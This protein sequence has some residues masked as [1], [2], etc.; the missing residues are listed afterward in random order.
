M[1]DF[2]GG[3]VRC[4]NFLT[5]TE[6][7]A[8]AA[9]TIAD[10]LMQALA[11]QGR[12]CMAVSGGKTPIRLF[13]QLSQKTLDWKNITITLVDERWLP[14]EHV[15]NN[16]SLVRSH[17]LQ[18]YASEA[19][20]IPLY[21]GSVQDAAAHRSLKQ[22]LS[23]LPT[24]DVVLLGMGEDGHTA[25]L[26]PN[27]SQAMEAMREHFPDDMVFCAPQHVEHARVSLSKKR[28]M[29]ARRFVLLL[30]GLSKKR[31]LEEALQGDD[32]QAMPIRAFLHQTDVPMDVFY[33]EEAVE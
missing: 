28:L 18:N 25:S 11:M 12:A 19:H 26:F 6:L 10:E 8:A 17:L 31:V 23:R 13:Q 16:E 33:S 27:D 3:R 14:V 1:G 22:R 29:D 24:F 4:E 7:Y 5:R 20:F 2:G 15:D 30:T 32:W 21:T 9:D